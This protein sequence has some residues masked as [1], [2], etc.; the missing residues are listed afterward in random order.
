MYNLKIMLSFY[1]TLSQ[2]MQTSIRFPVRRLE[3]SK[4]NISRH[5]CVIPGVKVLNL[6][7]KNS[8]RTS[9]AFEMESE[10]GQL[11]RIPVM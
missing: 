1:S 5:F 10:S 8:T 7:S 4:T 9:S 3:G 11:G 6:E 2:V